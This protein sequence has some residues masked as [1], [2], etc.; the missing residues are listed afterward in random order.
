MQ[1]GSASVRK[2]TCLDDL[3]NQPHNGFISVDSDSGG[4]TF[5]LYLPVSS[6]DTSVRPTGTV[7]S[8]VDLCGKGTILVVDDEQVQREI[9]VK[10]LTILG[11]EVM[12]RSSGEA[13]LAFLEKNTVDLVLLDMLM[14]P[15]INGR[16]TYERIIRIHPD[17][18][19]L[20][21]SG[22]SESEDIRRVMELGVC[23]LL[24]KPYTME[25]LGRAVHDA[26]Q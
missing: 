26:L 10:I 18:K 7:Q 12:A 5:T 23:G 16:Q 24:K 13:G 20:V 2:R 11:Y 4:T 1:S 8:L 22:F 17:Q 14:Q 21:V 6:R 15:G 9:A 25:E 3:F 19:A